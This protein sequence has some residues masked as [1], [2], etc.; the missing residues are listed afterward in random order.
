MKGGEEMALSDIEVP[1]YSS[2]EAKKKKLI[3]NEFAGKISLEI[4]DGGKKII[5]ECYWNDL[6]RA[7]EAVK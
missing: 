2:G 5:V 4:S 3:V 7:W 1:L 6:E